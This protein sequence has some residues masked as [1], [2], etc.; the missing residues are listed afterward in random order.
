MQI[1]TTRFGMLEV[2]EEDIWEMASP[3]L[4]FESSGRYARIVE[5]DSPFEFLQSVEDEHLTFIVTDPFLFLKEYD[6]TL[7][8]RWIDILH[9][10]DQEQVA[11]RTIVTVRSPN[12]ISM[13]LKAPIIM[14]SNTK[15]A[16]QIILDRSEYSTRHSI[17]NN[18]KVG[19]TNHADI[20]KE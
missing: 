20:I 15:E 4:G 2:K 9:L 18:S 12:D 10:E 5:N 11:V 1:N 14:N 8:Q 6:F 19:E 16:A 3:I 13:N 7:D 17:N